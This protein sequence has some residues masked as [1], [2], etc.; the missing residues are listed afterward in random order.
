MTSY[1]SEMTY[2]CILL[3]SWEAK[4][5]AKRRVGVMQIVYPGVRYR[6]ARDAAEMAD[7]MVRLTRAIARLPYYKEVRPRLGMHASSHL[8]A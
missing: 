8:E 3:N 2:D 6:L 1:E 4:L 5:F 7:H